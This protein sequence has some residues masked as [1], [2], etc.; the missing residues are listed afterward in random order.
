[1]H[2]LVMQ[3]LLEVLQ[4]DTSYL[5]KPYKPKQRINMQDQTSLLLGLFQLPILTNC[6]NNGN[7]AVQ[8]HTTFQHLTHSRTSKLEGHRASNCPTKT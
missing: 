1:M 3:H 2:L 7:N 5:W 4:Y 8:L 6:L